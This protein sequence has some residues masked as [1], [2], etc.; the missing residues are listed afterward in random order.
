MANLYTNN[1]LKH[2]SKNILQIYLINQFY[3]KCIDLLS[4]LKVDSILDAGCG[5]GYTLQVLKYNNIG[6]KLIGIDNNE[7]SLKIA[8]KI[9]R[10]INTKR[11]NIYKIPFKQSFFDL[12]VCTE[13]LEHLSKPSDAL[14]EL[15]RV[16]RSY[17]LLSV[18]NEP[19]FRILNFMRGKNIS[20]LGNDIDHINHWSR[21]SFKSFLLCNN[22]SIIKMSSSFPWLIVL[23][24]KSN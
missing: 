11:G 7:I 5:E 24:K 16:T 8:K 4:N 14:S 23:A 1:Y 3:K 13:V 22:L 10:D 18:P 9:F 20:R 15:C 19:W 2:Q 21:K 6:T 17:V 12:V